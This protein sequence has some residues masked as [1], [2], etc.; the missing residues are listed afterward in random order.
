MSSPHPPRV[1]QRVRLD[2]EHVPV[3]VRLW[4][5]QSSHSTR[6]LPH[7]LRFLQFN[8]KFN[9]PLQPGSIP[10]GVTHLNLGQLYNHSL[11][12]GVLPTSLRELHI[13]E[14]FDWPLEP[15][16]LPGGLKMIAFSPLCR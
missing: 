7:G 12:P 13:S 9:Q 6:L 3:R 10:H 16:S 14:T 5:V 1:Q 15:G 2:M 4:R 8:K 11:P